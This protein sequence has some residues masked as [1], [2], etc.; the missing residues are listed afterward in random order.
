MSTVRHL[1]T[2]TSLTI[3]AI[4]L[5]LSFALAACADGPMTTG[6]NTHDPVRSPSSTTVSVRDTTLGVDVR[7]SGRPLLLIHGGGEDASMVAAQAESLA[8]AGFRVVAYDRRGTGRSG[9]EDWPGGGAAQHADDAAALIRELGLGPTTVV[10]VSSGGVVALALATRHP[11]VVEHVVAWE[12]PALGVA[13]GAGIAQRALMAPA[14][15]YLARHPDDYIGA[16][17]ILLRLILGVPVATDDPAFAATRNNAEAMIRDEPG[18]PVYRFRRSDLAGSDVTIATGPSP[19]APIRVAA[20]RIS[21]WTG[22]EIVR[23]DADHEV[24]LSDPD[25]LTGI[26]TAASAAPGER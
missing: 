19:I 9:R 11:E 25:V 7:G 22:R 1:T 8:D 16:Q 17:A 26:V 15:R 24:Y 21:R 3:C 20:A 23:V 18:I 5:A 13:P 10:G 12:P 14:R 4:P 2:T 6:G